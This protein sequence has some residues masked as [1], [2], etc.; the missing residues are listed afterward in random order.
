MSIR[1]TY[2]RRTA[3]EQLAKAHGITLAAYLRGDHLYGPTAHQ[4]SA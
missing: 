2:E 1:V 4:R 3:L